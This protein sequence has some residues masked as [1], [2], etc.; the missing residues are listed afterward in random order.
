MWVSLLHAEYTPRVLCS[1]HDRTVGVSAAVRS[2]LGHGVVPTS[3]VRSSQVDWLVL[4]A[5]GHENDT[6]YRVFSPRVDYLTTYKGGFAAVGGRP[7]W[8]RACP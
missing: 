6:V 7:P 5:R 2:A 8:L 3:G 4:G 1:V